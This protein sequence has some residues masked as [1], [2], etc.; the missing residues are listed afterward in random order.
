MNDQLKSALNH[1][2][3]TPVAFFVYCKILDMI[4]DKPYLECHVKDLVAHNSCFLRPKETLVNNGFISV[5][6]RP[7]KMNIIKILKKDE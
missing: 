1:P 6:V 5:K 7:G 3:M 4:G 2:Q